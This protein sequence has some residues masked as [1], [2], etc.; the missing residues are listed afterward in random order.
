MRLSQLRDLL[1]L[2]MRIQ[3]AY[4]LLFPRKYVLSAVLNAVP[5]VYGLCL[6]PVASKVTTCYAFL[7]SSSIG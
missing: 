2:E 1:L 3:H 6:G 4:H 7:W 5:S